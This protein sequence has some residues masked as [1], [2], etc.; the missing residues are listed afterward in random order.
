MRGSTSTSS[1]PSGARALG[2]ARRGDRGPR[3]Q[4]GAGAARREPQRVAQLDAG[5]LVR[6]ARRP[7][8]GHQQGPWPHPRP[9]LQRGQAARHRRPLED[10]QRAASAGGRRQE[11]L[12]VAATRAW[13]SSPRPTSKRTRACGPTTMRRRRGCR[14]RARNA[15]APLEPQRRAALAGGHRDR[16]WAAHGNALKHVRRSGQ[17][18]SSAPIPAAW[19]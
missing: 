9:A 19:R 8:L 16:G 12:S 18:G 13:L 5:H 10:E 14:D 11:A 15:K 1:S 17:R 4:Q 6:S 2:R 3:R 7:A